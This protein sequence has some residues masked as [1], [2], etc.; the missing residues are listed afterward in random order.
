[1]SPIHLGIGALIAAAT[2]GFFAWLQLQEFPDAQ[3]LSITNEYADARCTLD[4]DDGSR[5]KFSLP[6]NDRY[7]RTFKVP[8]PGFVLMRC[9]T[10]GRVL[11]SPAHFHL[12]EGGLAS[13]HL[14]RWA[15]VEIFYTEGGRY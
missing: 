13:V 5:I 11:A 12:I 8:K 15:V 9:E 2:L 10:E 14:K 3:H 6:K 7:V 1:V 4:F